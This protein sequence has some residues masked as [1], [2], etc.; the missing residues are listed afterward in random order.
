[1]VFVGWNLLTT[2]TEVCF[3]SQTMIE[4][5]AIKQGKI[6]E[7]NVSYLQISKLLVSAENK[8]RAK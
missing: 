8:R 4:S 2:P 5:L 3:S 7:K 1:M 6:H